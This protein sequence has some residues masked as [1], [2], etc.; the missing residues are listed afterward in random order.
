MRPFLKQPLILTSCVLLAFSLYFYL[1]VER[2]KR[3]FDQGQAIL[4]DT[5]ESVSVQA[6]IDGNE[7][8]IR[9]DGGKTTI[10]RLLGIK[11]LESSGNDFTDSR[12]AQL[13]MDYLQNK[14]VGAQAKIAVGPTK[15]DPRGRLLAYVELVEADADE[16]DVGAQLVS[17]GL[18]VTFTKYPAPREERYLGL[19]A[20]ARQAKE[21][22][23]SSSKLTQEVL[24]KRTIWEQFRAEGGQ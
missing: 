3:Q 14:V 16:K 7:L 21:G 6:V 8:A 11:T 1:G 12:Y 23:W 24:R 10:V 18:A 9:G 13:A 5:G 2:L 20:L 22:L 15:I 17:Q 19:E 4:F